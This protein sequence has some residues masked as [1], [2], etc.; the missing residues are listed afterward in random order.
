MEDGEVFKSEQ[1]SKDEIQGSRDGYIDII[2]ISTP[3][4]PKIYNQKWKPIEFV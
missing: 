3:D 1:I 4:N 2:N